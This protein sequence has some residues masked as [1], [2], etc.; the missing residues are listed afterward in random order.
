MRK[1]IHVAAAVFE[2]A[3]KVLITA[4]PPGCP[5]EGMWEFP[6]GKIEAG[7]SLHTALRRELVEELGIQRVMLL[8]TLMRV[9]HDYPGK[10]VEI[11]FIRARLFAGCAITPLEGQGAKWVERGAISAEPL[12]PADLPVAQWLDFTR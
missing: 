5:L 8:D 1:T 3:N 9:T 4:R 10:S 2:C 11:T 7:E 12:L 6:G